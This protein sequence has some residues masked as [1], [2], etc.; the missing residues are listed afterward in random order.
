MMERGGGGVG[1]KEVMVKT[2]S[3]SYWDVIRVGSDLK[4]IRYPRFIF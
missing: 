3:K 1:K 2:S 4:D